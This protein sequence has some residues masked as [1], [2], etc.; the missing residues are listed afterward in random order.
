MR[1]GRISDSS[2]IHKEL[3]DKTLLDYK[4]TAD[5]LKAKGFSEDEIHDILYAPMF[6]Q[7]QK[8][9]LDVYDREPAILRPVS[10]TIG[11]VLSVP[12]M[13][14]LGTSHETAGLDNP[15]IKDYLDAVKDHSA[16]KNIGVYL[17]SERLLDKLY[18]T[19]KNPR[20][21]FG[22]KVMS[23]LN[24]P[25]RALSA[26]MSRADHYDPSS[27]TISVFHSDPAILAHELGHAMDFA[28]AKD[29]VLA[30]R[31]YQRKSPLDQEYLASNMAV[32][33]L[34]KQMFNKSEDVSPEDLK[35][36]KNNALKLRRAYNTYDR[37]FRKY[38]IQPEIRE[39]LDFNPNNNLSVFMTDPKLTPKLKKLLAKHKDV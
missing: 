12:A 24:F 7:S 10:S 2:R 18:R 5:E 23:T 26:A 21:G 15:D 27:D 16:L 32:N 4:P 14:H 35:K 17:G 19:W 9:A 39:L 30:N 36:L 38:G 13:D 37:W 33:A 25:L 1:I 11:K 31:L 29:H 22:S 28:T 20:Y 3:K 8:Q 34:A 6:G